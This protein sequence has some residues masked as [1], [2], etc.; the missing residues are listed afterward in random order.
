MK[1]Q[2]L[3][4]SQKEEVAQGAFVKDDRMIV[5]YKDDECDMYLQ[6][7]ALGGKHNIYNSMA[8]AIAAKAMEEDRFIIFFQ[9]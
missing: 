2:K 4:F 7:L 1:A 6:E 9:F 8:A 3:P 5:R